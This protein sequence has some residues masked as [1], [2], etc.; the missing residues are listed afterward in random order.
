MTGV[1]HGPAAAAVA[2]PDLPRRLVAEALGTLILVATVVGSGIMAETLTGDV[3]LA[4]LGNT[5]PTGAILVVLI[6][7]L[8]P[9]SGAHFNPAVTLA[10]CLRREGPWAEALPYMGAQVAGGIL[11]A[12]LAHAMFEQ[13]LLQLSTH[14]RT[15]PAQWLAEAVAT[16][17]LVFSILAAVRVRPPAVPLVVGLYIT[18]A[19]WFTASTSFANPAVAI[20]RALTDTF[21]GIRPAD[22]PG[23]ILAQLAGAALAAPFAAWLLRP[24]P[25]SAP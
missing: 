13:P 14:V 4:L 23:F 22:L 2:G 16:F 18:A 5:I 11:G 24:L 7:C 12:V 6:T 9:L 21:S 3:A 20:A 19:Y 17:G 25:R 10:L 1:V 15:G 8:G